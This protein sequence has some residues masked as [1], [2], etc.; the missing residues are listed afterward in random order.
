LI[1]AVELVC[2]TSA[3]RDAKCAA[4]NATPSAAA[5]SEFEIRDGGYVG[6]RTSPPAFA[7][8]LFHGWTLGWN[9]SSTERN[10]ADGAEQRS[11]TRITV[12]GKGLIGMAGER[13]PER[14][15]ELRQKLDSL[16]GHL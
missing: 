9:G 10:R 11:W 2:D 12:G 8:L 16:R 7:V 5:V 15:E 6:A 1:Q 14:I 13:V 4:A 3:A